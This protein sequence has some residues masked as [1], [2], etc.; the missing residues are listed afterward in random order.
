MIS[1]SKYKWHFENLS[2]GKKLFARFEGS[3]Y[4]FWLE[5]II[6]EE[7]ECYC[8]LRDFYGTKRYKILMSDIGITYQFKIEN[9][10]INNDLFNLTLKEC[11]YENDIHKYNF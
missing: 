2:F 9:L 6:I 3:I 5:S 1:L 11:D 4:K 7:K 10:K 8:I